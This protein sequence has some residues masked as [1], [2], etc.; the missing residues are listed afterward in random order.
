[1][2]QLHDPEALAGAGEISEYHEQFPRVRIAALWS[3]ADR[4]RDGRRCAGSDV[5]AAE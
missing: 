5:R 1:L 2:A 4:I 3:A